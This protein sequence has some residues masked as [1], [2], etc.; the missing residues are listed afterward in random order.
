[1]TKLLI[2]I[3]FP[4]STSEEQNIADALRQALAIRFNQILF[5]SRLSTTKLAKEGHK[6]MSNTCVFCG[7]PASKK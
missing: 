1:M 3:D 4:L 7:A 6:K 2:K 5:V